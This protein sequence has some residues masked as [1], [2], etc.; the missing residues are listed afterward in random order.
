MS[1]KVNTVEYVGSFP[2]YAKAVIPPYPQIAIAGRSNVGK[3]S[4][5]NKITNRKSIAKVSSTPGKTRLLNFFVVNGKYIIIDLPGYGYAKVSKKERARWRPMVEG[6]LK[7]SDRLRGLIMLIDGRRG[8][9][10]EEVELLKFCDYLS[11]NSFVVFTKVDKLKQS[12]RAKL[13]NTYKEC[14][15]FSAATGEG[16]QELLEYM[17]GLLS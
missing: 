17:F 7:G 8:A 2:D 15:F 11:I 1:I 3:S 16:K 4:L 5:I 6:L 12:Q 9:Q 10:N 14:L 13:R